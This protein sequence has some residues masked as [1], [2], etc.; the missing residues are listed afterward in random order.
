MTA[1][2][3]SRA[4]L[5]FGGN[6][7]DVLNNFV[8]ARQELTKH[9]QVE[10]IASSPLYQTAPV[11][12]PPGQPDYLNGVIEIQTG[13]SAPDL[14]QLCQQIEDHFGRI[15]DQRWGARTLDIDLLLVDN[16]V[17]ETPSLTLP[18][19]RM[20]QRRFVLQ[21]LNE[22]APELKHPIYD[23]TIN[24]LLNALPDTEGI[25]QLNPTW[26]SHD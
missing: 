19:P 2:N 22:L 26:S 14:L 5:G 7:G 11:G 6:L 3:K 1:K 18:H 12:G 16:Q 4:F 17:I 15:R 20:H 13:L 25:N 24:T 9:P 21:P 10:L 8:Y 23:T